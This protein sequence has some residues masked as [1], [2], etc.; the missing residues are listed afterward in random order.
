MRLTE[1][2]GEAA[3]R[4]PLKGTTKREVLLELIDALPLSDPKDGEGLLNAVLV[5]EEIMTTGIGNGIAIP[6]GV[7][8]I[9]D[10][11]V[12]SMGIA[13]ESVE[14]ESIDGAPVRL[15]F[16]LIANPGSEDHHLKALARIA[17]LL[18]RKTFRQALVSSNSP[19]EAVRVIREEESLHKI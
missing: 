7:F 6:H 1:L 16:L 5:R 10:P 3:A 15:F 12:G 13:P 9:Q 8:P 19:E 11:I 4:V 17:R 14:F 18:H 2:F